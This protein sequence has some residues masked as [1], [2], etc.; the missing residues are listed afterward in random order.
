MDYAFAYVKDAGTTLESDYPYHA[1]KS[2]FFPC[3][4]DKIKPVAYV[5]SWTDV[6]SG[7]ID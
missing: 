3:K 1:S 5:E 6:E 2:W 7:N 4:K